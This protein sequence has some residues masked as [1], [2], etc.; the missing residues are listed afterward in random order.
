MKYMYTGELADSCVDD[1][2]KIVALVPSQV[3]ELT[4]VPNRL[5][6]QLVEVKEVAE[7]APVVETKKA[8]KKFRKNKLGK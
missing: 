2:G 4:K 5:S 6:E 7:A 3:V 1:E 8:P